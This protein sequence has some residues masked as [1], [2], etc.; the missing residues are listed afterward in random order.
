MKGKGTRKKSKVGGVSHGKSSKR[1]VHVSMG[2]RSGTGKSHRLRGHLPK[3]FKRKL[4]D[5]RPHEEQYQELYNEYM[6][7]SNEYQL[8]SF[9]N[10]THLNL[11]NQL[12]E[13]LSQIR[14]KLTELNMS[15]SDIYGLGGRSLNDA[16]KKRGLF[17]YAEDLDEES[18]REILRKTKPGITSN[19]IEQIPLYRILAQRFFANS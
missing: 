4:N 8:L 15:D 1:T 19:Q 6:R 5:S 12:S 10:Y 11:T 7:L 2:T 16:L 18:K 3:L 17:E 13:I 9:Q 14:A